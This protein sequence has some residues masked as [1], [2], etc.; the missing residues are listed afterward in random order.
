MVQTWIHPIKTAS[1]LCTPF[2]KK[3]F[4]NLNSWCKKCKNVGE[5][6]GV[7]KNIFFVNFDVKNWCIKYPGNNAKRVCIHEV[8]KKLI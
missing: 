3:M 1:L 5:K 2:F 7:K 4:L 6:M 8:Q